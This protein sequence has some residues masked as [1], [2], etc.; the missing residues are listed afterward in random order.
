M[1]LP[2]SSPFHV[3]DLVSILQIQCTVTI[4]G[5]TLQPVLITNNLILIIVVL[6]ENRKEWTMKTW[7]RFMKPWGRYSLRFWDS[8][9]YTSSRRENWC[10]PQDMAMKLTF[11]DRIKSQSIWFETKKHIHHICKNQMKLKSE[12]LKSKLPVV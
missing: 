1:K 12:K 2:F 6:S 10:V 11:E 3:K 7:Q 5:I 8:K 9:L 4:K